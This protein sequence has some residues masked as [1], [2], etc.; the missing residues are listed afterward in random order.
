MDQSMS[1]FVKDNIL[2]LICQEIVN[3]KFSSGTGRTNC[4]Q[5]P[6]EISAYLAST[7]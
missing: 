7:N 5:D 4:V 2:D 3:Y 6:V 1:S